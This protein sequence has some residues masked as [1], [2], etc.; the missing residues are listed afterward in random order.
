MQEILE[1]YKIRAKKS[2]GQN[3]LMDENIL[4]QIWE[5]VELS[6][7]NI[8]EVGPGFWALTQKILS[9]TPQS[10]TLVELDDDM[11]R[12]LQDRIQ[13]KELDVENI[14]FSLKHQDVLVLDVDLKDYIV[15]ANIPYYITSP[16]LQKFLYKLENKPKNMIILMQKEVWDRICDKKSSILSLIVQ[17]KCT[18]SEKIFVPKKAF[19]PAPKVDSTVVFFETHG[20][21]EDVDDD[22]F[23]RFIKASFSNPRKK[24]INNLAQFW[25]DKTSVFSLLEERWFWENTRAEELSISDYVFLLEKLKNPN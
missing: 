4:T 18:T 20:L 9:Y 5:I 7:K 17:K 16:I 21:Y 8:I 1:R 10:L 22:I 6:G 19:S 12:I 2:L 24:M 15:V 11:V 23:L 14:D 25:Y 3:F 13:R